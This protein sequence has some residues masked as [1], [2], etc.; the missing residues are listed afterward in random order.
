MSEDAVLVR[1]IIESVKLNVVK[2][3][4]PEGKCWSWNNTLASQLRGGGIQALVLGSP[5]Y[6]FRNTKARVERGHWITIIKLDEE[7]LAVD[8]SSGQI[9]GLDVEEEW[10]ADSLEGLCRKVEASLPRFIY[11][12]PELEA[13]FHD[14]AEREF[15]RDDEFR[16]GRR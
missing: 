13:E 11:Y 8:L 14:A 5:H 1:E 16:T 6:E 7:W 2:G 4:D 12:K 10:S 9:E 15:K 3:Q